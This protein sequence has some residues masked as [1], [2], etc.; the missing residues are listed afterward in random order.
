MRQ[1]EWRREANRGKE[2]A[3]KTVGI[4]GY[5]RMGSAFAE[6][7]AGF[8][9]RVVAHDAYRKGFGTD[10]I[11]EVSLER[12]WEVSDVLS[13]HIDQ[14]PGNDYFINAAFL[15]RFAKP[16]TVI[17]TGRGSTL[18]TAALVDAMRR[19]AVEGA[20]LDVFEYEKRSFE[21]LDAS[22]LPDAL[23]WL[24]A[25]ERVILSP[26]VAGWS[27]ESYLKLSEVLADKICMR[28]T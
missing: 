17:N 9:C 15:E 3:G 24:Q 8:R 2:L 10:R 7:L 16:V 6:K 28:Y 27:V 14:R 11:E 13:I 25:S 18:D 4:L 20:C 19:G 23:R 22:A 12:L 5:G 26:H 1:G 21:A